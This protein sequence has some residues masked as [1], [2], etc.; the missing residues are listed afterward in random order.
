VRILSR[1]SA[2]IFIRGL[3]VVRYLGVWTVFS[4]TQWVSVVGDDTVRKLTDAHR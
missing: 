4:I 1:A 3:G 2:K